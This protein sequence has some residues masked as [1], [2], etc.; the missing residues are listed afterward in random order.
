MIKKFLLLF[1]I[2][3]LAA[4]MLQAGL[5]HSSAD[6][7]EILH[8][9]VHRET[10]PTPSPW[11]KRAQDMLVQAL[12]AQKKLPANRRM[13]LGDPVFSIRSS[14]L[15]PKEFFPSL[16]ESVRSHQDTID[17]YVAQLN[18]QYIKEATFMQETVLPRFE[19]RLPYLKQQTLN[20]QQPQDPIA[21][22][23]QHIPKQVNTLVIS[24]FHSEDFTPILNYFWQQLR[25]QRPN[26]KMVMLAEPLVRDFE[27][28]EISPLLAE[29]G[30]YYPHRPISYDLQKRYGR[31][32]DEAARQQIRIVGLEDPAVMAADFDLLTLTPEDTE[33]QMPY[34]TSPT[35]V[36]IRDADWKKKHEEILQ[37]SDEPTFVIYFVGGVHGSYNRRGSLTQDLDPNKTFVFSIFPS[38]YN[39]RQFNIENGSIRY[40]REDVKTPLEILTN[41]TFSTP[42]DFLYFPEKKDALAVGCDAWLRIDP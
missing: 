32:F 25:L 22:V 31:M 19:E 5:P 2:L 34:W 40:V 26:E 13:L 16:P 42:Q 37:E 18:E 36:G 33:E 21:F 8:L 27:W 6:I 15:P 12:A 23:A 9:L 28:T 35:G 10:R 38:S 20:F 39:Q 4:P 3:G 41:N 11:Q 17:Y 1:S 24:V 30:I 7:K 29:D 14:K